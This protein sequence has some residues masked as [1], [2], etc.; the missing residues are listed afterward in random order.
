MTMETMNLPPTHEELV[1]RVAERMSTLG[2]TLAQVAAQ[3]AIPKS[4][5]A[6]WRAGKYRGDV[7]GVDVKAQRWLDACAAGDEVRSALPAVPTFLPLPTSLAWQTVF[8]YARA[9]A[10]IGLIAGAPGTSKTMTARHYSETTPR[11]WLVTADASVASPRGILKRLGETLGME[12]RVTFTALVARL[13]G[14]GGLVI[15]DEAQHLSVRALD[16]L[17][18][19]NDLADLG[20]VWMGNEPLRA[21]IEGLGQKGS[22]AQISSRVGMF[23]SRSRPSVHDLNKMITAWGVDDSAVR[24]ALQWIGL[25]EGGLREVTKTLRYAC[26]LALTDGRDKPALQDIEASWTERRSGK[27]P[28]EALKNSPKVQEMAA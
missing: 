18:A 25:R 24:Q 23:K 19:V 12:G 6:E 14:T 22:T 21:A 27:L 15:V 20:M 8:E 1:A 26:L 13:R 2:L 4:T 16:Q 7:Q 10:D 3:S 28:K 9:A 17:R 11:V 5:L